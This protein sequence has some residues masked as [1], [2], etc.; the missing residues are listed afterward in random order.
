MKTISPALL[1]ALCLA[2][3]AVT[4]EDE[5]TADKASPLKFVRRARGE[6]TIARFTGTVGITGRFLAAWEG[7]DQK[8]RHMRVIFRPDAGTAALLPH[9][10]GADPVKELMLT[11]S[12]QAATMLL[13]PDAAGKLLAKTTLS[14]EGDATVTIGDYH[15]VV[16]CDHRWYMAR[17]VAVATSR[18]VVVAAGETRRYGC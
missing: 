6:D 9:A 4:A 7:L 15:A 13:G 14:A 5:F 16:E 10:T 18:D 17:L 1:L 8:P 12:E 11:N 2:A 3:S